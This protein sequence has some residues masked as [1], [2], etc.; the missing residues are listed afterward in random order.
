M[1]PL[2]EPLHYVDIAKQVM[3]QGLVES[4][5]ATNI[6]KRLLKSNSDHFAEVEAL[7]ICR[8]SL[9]VSSFSISKYFT[10]SFADRRR[11]VPAGLTHIQAFK[12]DYRLSSSKHRTNARVVW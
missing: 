7:F 5:E 1:L 8:P 4:A 3:R 11:D 10:P 9:V 6:I 12:A 2:G